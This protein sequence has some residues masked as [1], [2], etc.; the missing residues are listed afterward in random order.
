M[1]TVFQKHTV[2]TVFENQIK[3]LGNKVLPWA[4]NI[5]VSANVKF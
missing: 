2:S 3:L 1:K 4:K 5:K